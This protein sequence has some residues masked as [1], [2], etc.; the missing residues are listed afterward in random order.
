MRADSAGSV[1][2]A[3][4]AS[5]RHTIQSIIMDGVLG[6]PLGWS[7]VH[8]ALAA[9]APDVYSEIKEILPGGAG[10]KSLPF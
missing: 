7:K 6:G 1:S 3:T 5:F 8:A 4:K 10:D 9:A 2:E